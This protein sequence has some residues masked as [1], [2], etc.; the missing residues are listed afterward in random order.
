MLDDL[1]SS[2]SRRM[3]MIKYYLLWYYPLS[4]IK[5]LLN[6]S[7][8]FSEEVFPLVLGN[9]DVIIISNQTQ[10]NK[11]KRRLCTQ[12]SEL[13]KMLR[14]NKSLR[15]IK[16]SNKN[17]AKVKKP[18]SRRYYL[19]NISSMK[20]KKLTSCSQTQPS[21]KITIKVLLIKKVKK[22]LFRN[23]R[24]DARSARERSETIT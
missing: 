11:N 24:N 6:Y 14:L 16:S 9:K 10:T 7:W 15:S 5:S 22:Q 21:A 4:Y 20:L 13:R 17:T 3:R 19:F 8:C 2:P 18:I 12:S 1:W 23:I